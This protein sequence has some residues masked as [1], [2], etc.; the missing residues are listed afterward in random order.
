MG[1]GH[2]GGVQGEMF[3]GNSERLCQHYHYDSVGDEVSYQTLSGGLN[4]ESPIDP[5]QWERLVESLFP[6]PPPP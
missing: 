5:L 2:D 4:G 3:S 1:K 6:V